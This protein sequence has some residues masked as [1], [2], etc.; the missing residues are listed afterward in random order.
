MH[1]ETALSRVNAQ[2]LLWNFHINAMGPVLVSKVMLCLNA[3]PNM[4]TMTFTISSR[5]QSWLCMEALEWKAG[6]DG[7][8]MACRSLRRCLQRHHRY[9]EQ[10]SE[11]AITPLQLT[12]RCMC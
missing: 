8:S 1:A 5:L 10:A 12:M 6:I 9:M 2:N 3:A 11:S 4:A 7:F